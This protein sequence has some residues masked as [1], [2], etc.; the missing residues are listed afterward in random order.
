[1]GAAVALGLALWFIALWVRRRL[2]KMKQLDHE[3]PW[4][5]AR[6]MPFI[7]RF[8]EAH[9]AVAEDEH[10]FAA[11]EAYI[12]AFANFADHVPQR[13]EEERDD[14][15]DGGNRDIYELPPELLK[16]VPRL[17]KSAL[18]A[19]H[20]EWDYSLRLE[21]AAEARR[22]VGYLAFLGS[23]FALVIGFFLVS[24]AV[25]VWDRMFSETPLFACLMAMFA[26]V[27]LISFVVGWRIGVWSGINPYERGYRLYLRGKLKRAAKHLRRAVARHPKSLRANYALASLQADTGR[28]DDAADRAS[29]LL[30]VYVDSALVRELKARIELKRGH[31]SDAAD[32]Y[33]HAADDAEAVWTLTFANMMRRMVTFCRHDEV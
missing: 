23:W 13:R 1:M 32:E 26:I 16:D 4:S 29:Q 22:L 28:L 9:R 3:E 25:G 21:P 33:S 12:A 24:D 10:L 2:A 30:S 27:T 20:V 15:R 14:D 11:V 8:F 18:E 31:M 6:R 7:G 5:P 17:E 19:A